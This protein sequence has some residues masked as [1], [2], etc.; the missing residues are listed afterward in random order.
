M[1]KGSVIL[2]TQRTCW[3]NRC[4]LCKK[5]CIAFRRQADLRCVH[6]VAVRLVAELWPRRRKPA[7]CGRCLHVV[8]D[9]ATD[10]IEMRWFR[11]QTQPSAFVSSDNICFSLHC[12]YYVTSCLCFM[13]VLC[14]FVFSSS[15]CIVICSFFLSPMSGQGGCLFIAIFCRSMLSN[16]EVT[17]NEAPLSQTRSNGAV[18][19]WTEWLYWLLA[20]ALC[21]ED[22]I[23]KPFCN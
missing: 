12:G 9:S 2:P 18:H 16:K 10:L 1:R 23:I 20:V 22:I 5:Q 4:R 17:W 8:N 7:A 21:V 15:F 6:F 14:A 19:T 11:A 3:S 13:S